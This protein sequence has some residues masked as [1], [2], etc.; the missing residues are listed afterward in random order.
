MYTENYKNQL[1]ANGLRLLNGYPSEN[2]LKSLKNNNFSPILK[3]VA[4]KVLSERGV[5]LKG[6]KVRKRF[7]RVKFI[8][9]NEESPEVKEILNSDLSKVEKVKALF[10]KGYNAIQIA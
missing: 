7:K 4:V 3:V 10:E 5:D 1:H 2:I 6:I 8:P 9:M